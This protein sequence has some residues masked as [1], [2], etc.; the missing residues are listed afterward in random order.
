MYSQL[1][2]TGE[3]VTALDSDQGLETLIDSVPLKKRNKVFVKHL[4]RR[5]A[6]ELASL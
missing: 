1:Y 3:I 4:G 5:Q 6:K 2:F